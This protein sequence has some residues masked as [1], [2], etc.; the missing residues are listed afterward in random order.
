MLAGHSLRSSLSLPG[1]DLEV[2][3]GGTKLAVRSFW[4]KNSWLKITK[5]TIPDL[6]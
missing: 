6:G 3:A 1:G 5:K 2:Q 4:L